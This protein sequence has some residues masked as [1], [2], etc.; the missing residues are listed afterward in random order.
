MKDS[1]AGK[2]LVL[3]L[4]LASV[5]AYS[6]VLDRPTPWSPVSSYVDKNACVVADVPTPW[7]PARSSHIAKNPRSVNGPSIRPNLMA[8][9]P[10]PWPPAST[11]GGRYVQ[12]EVQSGFTG[13]FL[14]DGPTPWPQVTGATNA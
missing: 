10:T 14:A 3:T 2:L 8:D 1:V 5:G 12:N 6:I 9:G 4:A 7:P 11:G 13:T